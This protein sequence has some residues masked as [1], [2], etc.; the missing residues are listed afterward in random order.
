MASPS[1]GR[2]APRDG[3]EAD[4]LGVGRLQMVEE[5]VERD[6]VDLAPELVEE[7][8]LAAARVRDPLE[9]LVA[10][11][12]VEGELRGGPS[13]SSRKVRTWSGWP[14]RGGR[15]SP[16]GC[17][18]AAQYGQFIGAPVGPGRRSRAASASAARPSAVTSDPVL[19]R[20]RTMSPLAAS[21]PIRAARATRSPGSRP[22]APAATSSAIAV[23]RPRGGRR[24]ADTS[25]SATVAMIQ[26]RN[27]T[28]STAPA[29]DARLALAEGEV[30]ESLLGR[31]PAA[32]ARRRG[33]RRRPRSRRSSGQ[34]L[35]RGGVRDGRGRHRLVRGRASRA[36]T[37]SGRSIAAATSSMRSRTARS[38]SWPVA[39]AAAV[40]IVRS[41]GQ[42][43][44]KSVRRAERDGLADALLGRPLARGRS[45]PSR[46]GRRRPRSRTCWR[47]CAASPRARPRSPPGPRA[48]RP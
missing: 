6:E 31:P 20:S 2:S 3:W 1:C 25:G 45:R 23:R 42:A 8:G 17:P 30:G 47:R 36:G 9:A 29:P 27:A 7:V 24:N 44:T 48:G 15:G 19:S 16:S 37:S 38:P 12:A 41:F 28:G 14:S 39:F 43:V 11:R 34:D 33:R 40:Y 32:P 10:E 13:S 5:Q 26:P 21:T 46:S 35:G 22:N 18:R 4:Q